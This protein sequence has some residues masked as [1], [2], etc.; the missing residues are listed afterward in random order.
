MQLGGKLKKVIT[1]KGAQG[2]KGFYLQQRKKESQKGKRTKKGSWSR[3]KK[4][5]VNAEERDS[6]YKG[7]KC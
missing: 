2:Y 7:A 1:R 4:E 3:K 5:T 6:P